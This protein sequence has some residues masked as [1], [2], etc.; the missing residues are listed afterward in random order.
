MTW[1]PEFLNTPSMSWFSASV[2]ATNVVIPFFRA[3][4]ASPPAESSRARGAETRRRP[5]M[6]LRPQLYQGSVI[7]SHRDQLAIVFDD[8]SQSVDIVDM[9]EMFGLGGREFGYLQRRTDDRPNAAKDA[10]GIPS[11][12]FRL[13]VGSVVGGRSFRPSSPRRAPTQS[14]SDR[15]NLPV[16]RGC[17][18]FIADL[19]LIR[20][21]VTTC[22]IKR[23]KVSRSPPAQGPMS[24]I[25]TARA[26]PDRLLPGWFRSEARSSPR[27]GPRQHGRPQRRRL[28]RRDGPGK[29]RWIVRKTMS[30]PNI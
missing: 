23:T 8:E 16:H 22:G 17:R 27:S 1:K 29:P 28:H 7:A 15:A 5:Q 4:S 11:A 24:R 30:S 6:Q 21:P 3:A 18:V 10:G 14:D 25:E 20:R 12:A 9:G 13:R 2:W 19:C 26:R